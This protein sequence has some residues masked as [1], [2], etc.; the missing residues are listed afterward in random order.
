MGG[1][2]ITAAAEAAPETIARLVYVT[3]FLGPSGA[4]MTGALS[5]SAGGQ[6]L[7]PVDERSFGALYHDCPLEDAMLAR[8]CLTPQALAPLVAPIC[9][10][11]ERWGRIP[12]TFVGCGRDRVFGIAEQR[13]RAGEIPGTEM[14]ALDCGH[15]PFFSMPE[16]LA[17]LLDTLAR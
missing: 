9:W 4:S 5:A 16:P 13:R 17:D 1:A 11:P 7:I 2:A 8:L 14:I 3:A 10:T 12:R 6:D 15:S